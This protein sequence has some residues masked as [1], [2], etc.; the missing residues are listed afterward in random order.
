MRIA[1]A[2]L[3]ARDVMTIDP[4]CVT[5]ATRLRELAT[6]FEEH[7]ISGV[8]VIDQQGRVVGVVSKT[9]LIR[10]CSQG[11]DEIPPAFLFEVLSEQGDDDVSEAMPEPLVCV[12]DIMT[13]D[14]LMVSPDVTA[15]EVA[16]I[17]ADK[18]VHRVIVTDAD[19]FP[20][21]IITSLDLLASLSHQ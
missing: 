15:A 13:P 18:R 20:I 17:M 21:G 11:T 8:P 10:R 12:D 9:D 4:V 19:L 3:T 5:P 16:R 7:E 6:I 1:K 2:S 14:P